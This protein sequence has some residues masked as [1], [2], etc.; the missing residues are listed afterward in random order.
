M[1]TEKLIIQISETGARTVKREVAGIGTAANVSRVQVDGMRSSLSLTSL[2]AGVGF[3]GAIRAATRAVASFEQAM[4]TVRAVSSATDAQFKIMTDTARYLG[5]TTRFTATQAAEGMMFLARAGFT[6][7][8]TMATIDDTLR[9][10][11][12]AALDLGAAAEVTVNV[13]N[14]MRLSTAEA[15]RVTDVLAKT[16]NSTS[17]D[18]RQLGDA[19]KYAGPVAAGVKVPLE[20]MTAVIGALSDA[21]LAGS[22]AGTGLRRIIAELEAPTRMGIKVLRDLGVSAKEVRV[23]EVG[24]TVAI[25]RLRDAGIDTGQALTIFGDRGGPAFEIMASSV[26]KIKRLNEAL[27]GAGGEA[28]RVA[29]IMD[30]NLNG[31][32]LALRSAAEAAVL[33]IGAMKGGPEAAVRALAGGVR[34]LANHVEFLS[35]AL[36]GL[37]VTVLPFLHRQFA[38]LFLLMR[39]HPLMLLAS[40]IA[41]AGAL[42]YEFR[43]R[44]KVSSDGLVSLG[45][46]VRAVMTYVGEALQAVVDYVRPAVDGVL[47]AFGILAEGTSSSFA[48]VV[49]FVAVAFDAIVAVATGSIGAIVAS[50]QTMGD[51]INDWVSKAAN[52]WTQSFVK[53]LNAV[54]RQI[55]NF[56]ILVEKQINIMQAFYGGKTVQLGLVGYLDVPAEKQRT[57]AGFAEIGAAARLGFE[58]GFRE[59]GTQATD[60][61]QDVMDRARGFAFQRT[62]EEEAAP[63]FDPAVM[64]AAITKMNDLKNANDG[65]NESTKTFSEYLSG[66]FTEGLEGTLKNI[67]DIS[68]AISGTLSGAFN[69]ATDA[70]A[71]FVMSGFQNVEDLKRA[72]SDLFAQL[73]KDILSLIIRIL[74]MK[75]IAGV[76]GESNFMSAIG[77][78]AGGAAAGA[79]TGGGKAAGGS[80]SLGR[81]YPVGERGPEIFVPGSSGAIVPMGPSEPPQ[82]NLI[83]NNITD[84]AQ[85]RA[86]MATPE[87]GKVM[88]NW[89]ASN[90]NSLKKALR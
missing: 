55:N 1:A 17:T 60:V 87:G 51:V 50:F 18:V 43:N 88:M 27:N 85:A 65:A 6:A 24:L 64:D 63:K 73:A 14:G 71:D 19:I 81:A 68:G 69:T 23:S 66:Q 84:P 46:V 4:G 26:P 12:A 79:A 30:R 59:V 54:I 29:E 74:I 33:S 76:M 83:V 3:L 8:Q 22:L 2:I 28:R 58:T 70:L 52:F 75:A 16:A 34:F 36:A 7:E 41:A 35:A 5:M 38:K 20:E 78:A 15:A 90:R 57:T 62:A 67:S 32:F 11:Q 13:L 25:E 61:V 48:D 42:L 82:V 72:F 9:L 47:S 86:A 21:G 37:A 39:A 56:I 45:D 77:G 53:M 44:I 10:A 89:V 31:A 80:V 40:A 49:K